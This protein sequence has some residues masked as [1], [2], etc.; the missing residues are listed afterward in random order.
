MSLLG[1]VM[2]QALLT[3]VHNQGCAPDWCQAQAFC[4]TASVLFFTGPLPGQLALPTRHLHHFHVCWRIDI[5]KN[6]VCA[7]TDL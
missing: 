6:S 3:T 7:D 4:S 5:Y 2:S 1:A